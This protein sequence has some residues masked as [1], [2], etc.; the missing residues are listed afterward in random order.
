MSPIYAGLVI[1]PLLALLS[2]TESSPQIVLAALRTL[3]AVADS[4]L[5]SHPDYNASDDSLLNLL[6]TEQ[7]LNTVT[8]ILLQISPSLIAQQQIALTASLISKTCRDEHHRV[9][10]AQT[11]VLEALA[12]K[13][14]SFVVATCN[15]LNPITGVN[16]A[17]GQVGDIP[18]ANYRSRLLPILNAVS[19]IIQH[20]KARAVQFLS[21]PAFAV[22]FQKPDADARQS[23]DRKGSSW[24]FSTSSTRQTTSSW[25]ENLIPSLPNS[26]HR[27]SLAQQSNFPPLGTL[28]PSGKQSQPSRS[29]SSAIE[30]I[31][32]QGLEF[33][34]EEESP[35]IAWLLYIAR[36]QDQL[37]GLMAA[38]TLAILY[39]HG[40]TKRGRETA[41]AFLLVPLLTRMLDKDLMIFPDTSSTYNLDFLT[42]PRN[43]IRERAP[44]VLAMLAANSAE[45]QKAAADAGAIKKLSQ[46]LK[47]SYDE[48]TPNSTAS[49]WA[50]DPASSTQMETRDEGSRLGPQGISVAARHVM[51]LR[52]AVLVA[53]A[54]I[55]SDKDEY[56]K[57]IIGNGIIPFII[58]T[59]ISEDT[60]SPSA[61][62]AD[63]QTEHSA[64][65][66]RALTRN[67]RNAI[68]AA[69]G[70]ARALSRSVSTMRTSL[71]DAGLAAP[72]FTLLKCQDVELQIAATAVLANLVLSFSPMRQVSFPAASDALISSRLR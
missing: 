7:T 28:G 4:L 3:N 36:E 11:G 29:F 66:R 48:I 38:W 31:Q 33:V 23:Y 12:V 35:L 55:A 45:V 27:S 30:V 19:A 42:S 26:H 37:T 67:G 58:K 44:L 24:N 71:M 70:A 14:A 52:E 34:E 57:E 2:P 17:A 59:L 61:P 21:A 65:N 56:R 64:R 50:P 46:L 68:L 53:L 13:L 16:S 1:S 39:R 62:T 9:M 8:N 47:E 15:S 6:Y 25:I 41:F 54:A 69:C 5:L 32:S 51:R 63:S 49:L 72:L 22:I 40:L 10:L 43:V 20:S 60:D 18:P